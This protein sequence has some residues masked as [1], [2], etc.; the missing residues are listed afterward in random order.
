MTSTFYNN[1]RI[2]IESIATQFMEKFPRKEILKAASRYK[3]QKDTHEETLEKRRKIA[4]KYQTWVNSKTISIKGAKES[5]NLVTQWGFKRR[6]PASIEDNLEDF[7]NMI[8][9]WRDGNDFDKMHDTL[10]S[11]LNLKGVGIA[12]SS[13]WLCFINQNRYCIYD[14]RVS[15]T[16]RSLGKGD[17]KTFPTCPRQT[18]NVNFPK[19]VRPSNSKIALAYFKYLDLAHY[20][21]DQYDITVTEI[22]IGLFMLG[23]C[24][25]N[26]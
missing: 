12:R 13:K 2:E 22:E 17:G 9:I 21:A 7:R 25:S 3:W 14:S 6:L 8:S 26:W 18:G 19:S 4:S 23:D 10:V 16:L 1:D 24:E 20:I 15:A 5:A 11:N